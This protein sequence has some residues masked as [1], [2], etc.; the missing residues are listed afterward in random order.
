MERP[1]RLRW[2]ITDETLAAV[3]ADKKLAKLQPDLIETLVGR[4]AERAGVTGTDRKTVAMVVDP[5][6]KSAGLTAG[7][8]K[9]VWADLAVQD[10]DA[11]V[12]T[13]R[14]GE[15]EPDPDLR[16]QENVALP[17]GAMPR[18][19]ADANGRLAS[20]DYVDAV[21]HH[22]VGEVHPYVPDA[23]IDHTKTKIGYE[24]P[25]TRHFYKY[26]PPRALAEIDAEI[27]QL[28]DEIQLLLDEVTE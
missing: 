15:P 23:W 12:I 3:R 26:V 7:Q 27:K 13:N 10:P 24:I 25:L 21:E 2:E 11:P 17:S 8:A 14:R 28:E 9:A 5:I 18:Y 16:D 4:L 19:E 22:L 6:L 1:L 20:G